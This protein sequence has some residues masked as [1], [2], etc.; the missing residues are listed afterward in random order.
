MLRQMARYCT[1][2]PASQHAKQDDRT[3]QT[4]VYFE[5]SGALLVPCPA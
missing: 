4:K 5:R 1:R 3:G 2:D